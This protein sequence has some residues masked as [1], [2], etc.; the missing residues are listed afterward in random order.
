[1][2][3][4]L[5][6]AGGER[7]REFVHE[8]LPGRVVF[9][10][11]SVERVPDELES[12]GCGRVL[13]IAGGSA[14]SPGARI[15][16][17]LGSSAAGHFERIR[18]H[19]PE[20]LAAEAKAAAK[21]AGADGLC[22]VGGGSATGLAK[23]VAVD[24]GLP[25]LAV[26][27]TYAGSEM[28]PIYGITGERKRT[29]R[30][31]R[32]LPKTVVYDPALTTGLPTRATATSGF[33]AL[34]QAVTALCAPDGSP[35]AGL[36]AEEAVRV[37]ARALPVAVDS[38]ADLDARG[39]L[40]FGACLAGSALA[41]TRTG[42]HHRLCHLI[43]GSFGLV[44]AEVHAVLLPYTLAHDS[45]LSEGGRGRVAQVLGATDAATGLHRL[46]RAVGV[47]ASLADIGMPAAGLD[48]VAV[49][50]AAGGGAG[51]RSRVDRVRTL[52][53]DAY[54]GRPPSGGTPPPTDDHT[55]T[56]EGETT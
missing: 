46:G 54:A 7:M 50:A 48:A 6:T 34:A 31:P 22:S 43:G 28:T 20:A 2:P 33:N 38:P 24:L 37:V 39:D 18:Q 5:R 52:L 17:A 29:G 32:A 42:L 44:H 25:I 11:G 10:A 53:D 36:H 23:A 9:G 30:D 13:I 35:V 45:R 40:L 19:V 47:P 27:T 49:E 26:P 21:D 1:M 51:S 15:V 8:S 4:D 16:E 3:V 55:T 41:S 14:A 12:L 56:N